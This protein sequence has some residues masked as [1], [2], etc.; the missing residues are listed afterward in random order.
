M[1]LEWLLI[2][3]I[4]WG[5][6]SDMLARSGSAAHNWSV[7]NGIFLMLRNEGLIFEKA[8]DS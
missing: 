6:N 3:D 5:M 1:R 7:F 2:S 8:V 4:G